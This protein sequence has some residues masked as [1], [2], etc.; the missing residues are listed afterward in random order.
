MDLMHASYKANPASI[1]TAVVDEETGEEKR[2]LINRTRWKGFGPIA[3]NFSE[4]GVPDK[5]ADNIEEQRP[6]ADRKL[7]QRLQEASL[8]MYALKGM[9]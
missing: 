8:N 9:R 5:P 4:K 1:V 2:R 6:Q 7:L 3:I